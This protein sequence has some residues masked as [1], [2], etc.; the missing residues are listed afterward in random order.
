MKNLIIKLI[1]LLVNINCLSQTI[2]IT[3]QDGNPIE[4][5]YYEDTNGYLNPFVGT[6]KYT[7][8]NTSI[9]IKLEKRVSA[10]IGYSYE[11]LL[12]GEYKYIENGVLKIDT[13]NELNDYHTREDQYGISGNQIVNFSNKAMCFDCTP[14]EIRV[15]CSF[16]ERQTKN[17][18]HVVLA[19]TIINGQQALKLFVRY[20]SRTQK[21][22]T[23]PNLV[24]IF[25][26]GDWVLIKQ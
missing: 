17:Y 19:K 16:R 11:D 12:I 2:N 23:P 13:L 24:N 21:E 25:P 6:Y 7:N 3:E 9:T 15:V 26:G 8:G 4:G 5:A 14:N 18:G 10:P 22:G 20:Y 1:I